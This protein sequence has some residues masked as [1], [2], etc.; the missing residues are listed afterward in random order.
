MIEEMIKLNAEQLR[1]MISIELAQTIESRR[2]SLSEVESD[3]QKPLGEPTDEEVDDFLFH[4]ILLD[5]EIVEQLTDPGLLGFSSKKAEATNEWLDE[6]IQNVKAWANN[7][8]WLGGDSAIRQLMPHLSADERHFWEPGKSLVIPP[9][10]QTFP[11]YILKALDLLRKG[12]YLSELSFRDFEFLVGEL[13]ASEGWDVEVTQP[14]RDGGIDIVASREDEILGKIKSVWQAKKQRLSNKVGLS[15]VREL[16]G[17]RDELKATKAMVV[18]TS[19]LTKD[20]ISW[21][22]RDIYRLGYL[23]SEDMHKW[24]EGYPRKSAKA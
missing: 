8:S 15:T 21:I 20:A 7:N 14:T 5:D 4:N 19:S 6:F 18:T 16:S 22:Q 17:I 1:Q 12:N 13:L 2:G 11:P 23:D 9:W 24:L 3:Y 10:I